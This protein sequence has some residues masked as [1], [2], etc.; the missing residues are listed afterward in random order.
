MGR[1]VV[2]I[3]RSDYNRYLWASRRGMLE[4]D[5]MMVPFMEQ[6]FKQLDE[7]NQQRYID[8]LDSEDTDLFSWLLGREV[9]SNP[10]LAVIINKI[11]DFSRV[12]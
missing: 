11:I 8:L 3:S 6:C 7:I 1:L 12:K 5:L 2:M 4:L 9:P 10:E